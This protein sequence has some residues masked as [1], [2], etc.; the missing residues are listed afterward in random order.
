MNRRGEVATLFTIAALAV[1]AVGTFLGAQR[2]IQDGVLKLGGFAAQYDKTFRAHFFTGP[3]FE[4][5]DMVIENGVVNPNL[6]YVLVRGSLCYTGATIPSQTGRFWV[7]TPKDPN[8]AYR[9]DPKTLVYEGKTVEYISSQVSR[10]YC[11]SPDV[12]KANWRAWDFTLKLNKP[13]SKDLC[14]GLFVTASTSFVFKDPIEMN[15]GEWYDL[16]RRHGVN[17]SP[18][19]GPGPSDTPTPTPNNGRPPTD[20]PTPSLTAT[21]T[22]RT[23]TVTPTKLGCLRPCAV[24][25]QCQPGLVCKVDPCPQGN[26]TT[27]KKCQ[28]EDPND[29]RC[30]FVTNTPTPTPAGCN[31]PCTTNSNCKPNF[32][33][34][35]RKCVPVDPIVKCPPVPVTPNPVISITN[36]PIISP[37]QPSCNDCLAR[38]NAYRCISDVLR[39]SQP[40]TVYC[41]STN[42]GPPRGLDACQLCTP[43]SPTPTDIRTTVIR[44]QPAKIKGTIT[45]NSCKKPD[46]V[47]TMVCPKNDLDALHC[48]ERAAPV[49]FVGQDP[50]NKNKWLYTYEYSEAPISGLTR[51]EPIER[52]VSY[53]NLKSFAQYAA[54]G[55]IHDAGIVTFPPGQAGD[56][57]ATAFIPLNQNEF[58]INYEMQQNDLVCP[59][60]SVTPSFTPTPTSTAPSNTP[61]PGICEYRSIATV[62]DFDTKLPIPV[63]QLGNQSKWG[64]ANDQQ[65]PKPYNVFSLYGEKLPSGE[66]MTQY[67]YNVTS[68]KRFTFRDA[69]D[70]DTKAL[71]SRGAKA[72][73]NLFIDTDKWEIVQKIQCEGSGCPKPVENIDGRPLDQFGNTSTGFNINCGTDVKYGWVVKKRQVPPEPAKACIMRDS[74]NSSQCTPK[75]VDA[76]RISRSTVKVNWNSPD[77][78]CDF[79]AGTNGDHYKVDIFDTTEDRRKVITS[80]DNITR[81]QSEC[82]LDVTY[83]PNSSKTR[84]NFKRGHSYLV[85]VYAVKN[86]PGASDICFSNPNADTFDQ[87]L[88]DSDDK[89]PPENPEPTAPPLGNEV[90]TRQIDWIREDNTGVAWGAWS[91]GTMC[92]LTYNGT[93]WARSINDTDIMFKSP[94]NPQEVTVGL[95]PEKKDGFVNLRPQ[96]VECNACVTASDGKRS[97]CDAS[98]PG[99]RVR[100]GGNVKVEPG[101]CYTVNADLA[102]T[103]PVACGTPDGTSR[104]PAPPKKSDPQPTLPAPT[105]GPTLAQKDPSK[106]VVKVAFDIQQGEDKNQVSIDIDGNDGKT[107][108]G[109]VRLH[110]NADGLVAGPHTAVITKEFSGLSDLNDYKVD[111]RFADR[112][113][114]YLPDESYTSRIFEP[115]NCAD[116]DKREGRDICSFHDGG[117][118]VLYFLQ[119]T[120]RTGVLSPTPTKKPELRIATEF[121]TAI[122]DATV[123]SSRSGQNYGSATDLIVGTQTDITGSG[124]YSSLLKFDL[125]KYKDKKIKSV[126]LVLTVKQNSIKDGTS[127]LLGVLSNELNPKWTE[128]GLTYKNRPN[129][130]SG[131]VI[132]GSS[133]LQRTKTISLN[134][135]VDRFRSLVMNQ[136]NGLTLLAS[137]KGG[138]YVTFHSR[139]SGDISGRPHFSIVLD[140]AASSSSVSTTS[141]STISVRN[142]SSSVIQSLSIA[143]C[144][145]SNQCTV[146]D[147]AIGLS[148]GASTKFKPTFTIPSDTL[149][150][151][152]VVTYANGDR[153]QCAPQ[154]VTQ[155]G[156]DLQ[157]NVTTQPDGSVRTVVLTPLKTA[158][159]NGDCTVTASDG[160][161]L[162]D[163]NGSG[164]VD[165]A[166]SSLFLSF[167]GQ[168]ACR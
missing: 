96:V 95:V 12:G 88:K 60:P 43:P 111:V 160:S 118:E 9:G 28:P 98:F 62:I 37:V 75:N 157:F 125:A 7:H 56:R 71:Y 1:M 147:T 66:R 145:S 38:G 18:T 24:D 134:M 50:T 63:S 81:T 17:C 36:P 152:C 64:L 140:N 19:G 136:A 41:S 32:K 101:K 137:S 112:S 130:N 53:F 151:S 65:M 55:L 102:V 51:N 68:P 40:P 128:S 109:T 165:A 47:T 23:P 135:D 44:T 31:Q 107:G 115:N 2:A 91:H 67:I 3:T 108:K 117:G 106:I 110:A 27:V 158:D 13:F 144:N 4:E 21:P 61:T 58:I 86:I 29:R 153:K 70:L 76:T 85:N 159:T 39:P 93:D 48:F 168:N 126:S 79:S 164:S 80:C 156:G 8:I 124:E 119:T 89:T 133:I 150:L 74:T 73:V 120:R 142:S 103:G 42:N 77:T 161:G 45:V 49:T 82:T 6:G 83:N 10:P 87:P 146:N 139:E 35:N 154:L 72:Q 155:T 92:T 97:Q 90:L 54:D 57:K 116:K 11:D 149:R 127:M 14:Q 148:A 20:T 94:E 30:A 122:A 167:I 78:A 59:P 121:A 166:D 132:V 16:L 5:K 143:A 114:S 84:G 100:T 26:C 69:P 46:N 105:A 22:P 141:Q 163:L 25:S 34:D 123:S 33:C 162:R 52:G 104:Q 138:G 131:A 129:P 15:K 113:G 99:A